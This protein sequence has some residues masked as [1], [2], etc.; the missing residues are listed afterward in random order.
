MVEHGAGYESEP[1]GCE[2][3]GWVENKSRMNSFTKTVHD[4]LPLC[5]VLIFEELILTGKNKFCKF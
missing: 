1:S 5:T 2:V 4:Q 3:G